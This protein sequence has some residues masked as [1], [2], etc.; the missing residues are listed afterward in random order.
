MV[1]W[2]LLVPMAYFVRNQSYKKNWRGDA[3]SPAGYERANV[4]LLVI[5][6]IPCVLGYLAYELTANPQDLFIPL[7]VT[8]TFLILNFPNGKAMRPMPPRFGVSEKREPR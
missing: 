7:G 1:G 2:L 5:L 3:I 8:A 4:N 6:E